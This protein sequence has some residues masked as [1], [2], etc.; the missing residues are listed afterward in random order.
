MMKTSKHQPKLRIP[1]GAK[2]C[3]ALTSY[4]ACQRFMHRELILLKLVK[5]ALSE[6]P[7]LVQKAKEGLARIESGAIPHAL[8]IRKTRAKVNRTI[9]QMKSIRFI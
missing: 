9:F 4:I 3:L 1:K 2:P 6:D 7:Y 8:D 5:E